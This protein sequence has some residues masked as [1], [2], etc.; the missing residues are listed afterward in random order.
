MQ[1]K[2]S[3][4]SAKMQSRCIQNLVKIQSKCSQISVKMQSKCS[5]NAAKI[6]SKC[7][8]ISVKLQ[9]NSVKIA[10]SWSAYRLKSFQ[11]C[12]C[13]CFETFWKNLPNY[14]AF[15][16]CDHVAGK[17]TQMS[18]QC[19]VKFWQLYLDKVLNSNFRAENPF[20]KSAFVAKPLFAIY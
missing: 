4:N 15:R 12:F 9:P 1:S 14:H 6:Q 19:S 18:W 7:S 11:S 2:C 10:S 8:Q 3:Q 16:T 17:F 13:Q 5:Q 20:C